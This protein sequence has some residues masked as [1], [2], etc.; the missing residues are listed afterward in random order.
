MNRQAIHK[1]ALLS[2]LTAAA[3][4]LFVF[5]S[6]VPLPLPWMRLGLANAVTLIV[7]VWW[8]V[9]EATL[10]V[11]ARAFI[12]GLLLGRFLDPGF[13]LALGGGVASAW[14]MAFVVRFF[15][16]IWGCVGISIWGALAKNAA[17]LSLVSLLYMRSTAVFNMAGIFIILSLAAGLLTG[18]AALFFLRRFPGSGIPF[19]PGRP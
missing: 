18:L 12:G 14:M 4:V 9:K 16:R 6:L 19:F 8:G 3:G 7:I 1:L 15:S 5:E 11:I 17:Q 10:L 13:F 2:L